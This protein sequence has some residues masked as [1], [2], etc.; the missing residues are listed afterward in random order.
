MDEA[1]DRAVDMSK[2]ERLERSQ[3]LL[4]TVEKWD[5]NFWS[6]HVLKLFNQLKKSKLRA[7]KGGKADEAA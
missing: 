6:D 7:L 4:N 3:S 1:I 5:I 2:E